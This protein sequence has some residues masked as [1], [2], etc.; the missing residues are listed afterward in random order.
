MCAAY[1]MSISHGEA[2]IPELSG[3]LYE[4]VNTGDIS[5]A[6]EFI[7]PVYFNI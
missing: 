2:R 3:Q 6:H 4:A 7:G 5:K 1:D